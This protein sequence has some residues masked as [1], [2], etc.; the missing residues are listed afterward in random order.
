MDFD[1]FK[2]LDLRV[3]TVRVAERHPNADRILRLEIDFGE[4]QLRQT[5]QDWRNIMPPMIWW[6]NRSAPC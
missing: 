1:H 5:F 6:A 2:A 4:G 3:G